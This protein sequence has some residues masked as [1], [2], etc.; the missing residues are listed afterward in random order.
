[1][2]DEGFSAFSGQHRT[3]GALGRFLEHV[4]QGRVPSGSVLIVE[5][6][7]RLSREQVL[8]AFDLFRDIIRNRIKIV[9]L[10]DNM[11]YT[12]ETLNSHVGQ[13]M[14]SL[15]IMSRAHEESLTKSK[16]L[17]SAWAGK[18]ENIH[19]KKLTRTCPAWL[20]LNEDR[21]EF[22]KMSDRCRIIKRIFEMKLSGKGATLITKELNKDKKAWKP[23]NGWRESYVRKIF[24]NRAVIGEFQ[25]HRFVDGKRIPDGEPILDYF[26]RV[27]SD[28][29]FYGVQEQLRRNKYFRGRHGK[30]NNLF[31]GLAKCG[32]CGAPMQF[33]DK[34][35]TD[36]RGQ[37]LVCDN[38]RRGRGC[39][40]LTVKYKEVEELILTYCKGLDVDDLLNEDEDRKSEI[41][42]ARPKSSEC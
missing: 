3:K 31:G 21:T 39:K 25:P 11:E 23:K 41:S 15:T 42:S 36:R 12:E 26:P 33:I 29:L 16:R 37:Y 9:T 38:A 6:L 5:S 35:G 34:G 27:V 24:I 13:L 10:A 1:L 32:Y 4:E 17:S 14:I 20:E 18:R 2:R 30:I 40:L 8:D 19:E 28:E 7:D 22:R